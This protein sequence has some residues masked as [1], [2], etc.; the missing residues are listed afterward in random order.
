MR[1]KELRNFNRLKDITTTL[2][3]HG[4]HHFVDELGLPV[5]AKVRS[6]FHQ[7]KKDWPDIAESLPS[8]LKSVFQDLGPTFIKLGQIL[9]T[10]HDLLGRDFITELEKLQ[11]EVSPM[12]FEEVHRV[13]EEE[14]GDSVEEL[15]RE[16]QAEPLGSA[17]I[18][19][20][21]RAV[22][23]EGR[24]LVVKVQRPGIKDLIH[25]DIEVLRFVAK[26]M[27]DN[28]IL[29]EIYDPE[30]IVE[31]F[32]RSIKK[33]LDYFRELRN[34]YAF[35]KNFAEVEHIYLPEVF[36]ELSTDKVLCMEYVDG[37]KVSQ[38][39]RGKHDF[40]LIA[41]RGA[42]AV[43]KQVFEDG[44]FH[45]DPHPGNIMIKGSAQVCFIDFGMVGRLSQKM[46]D[47][48][49]SLL[50]AMSNRDY[51][52]LAR[53]VIRICNPRR[54]VDTDELATALLETMDPFYGATLGQI[55]VG[56]LI[57]ECLDVIARHKIKFPSAYSL[58]FKSLISIES[59]G[60]KLDP[61]F[62]LMAAARPFVRALVLKRF[63][64]ERLQ[65]DGLLAIRD[66]TGM[67][68]RL[69]Y[70]LEGL[71]A[72]MLRGDF[73]IEFMHK[74]LDSLIR[75]IDEGSNR[76]AFSLVISACIMA[77]SFVMTNESIVRLWGMNMGVVM[78]VVA[79]LLGLWLALSILRS[80]RM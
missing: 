68:N 10:R 76:I 40:E 12:P 64:L 74:G 11:D 33:E 44:C 21:H 77:S 71:L 43:L 75:Q 3:S 50:F 15:F 7:E 31:E 34:I 60:R 67:L 47:N 59:L 57:Q 23:K 13:I 9:S 14:L 32:A 80:G 29:D 62:D 16:F 54:E 37:I 56:Q 63:G 58:I 1:L 28:E 8:R 25:S 26:L 65:R 27:K 38:I 39:E 41:E 52:V 70:R 18:G 61:N 79:G 55:D 42:N 5:M 35:R 45:A 19:Q 51:D 22:S 53:E 6:M 48:L 24:E 78:W 36:P 49:S 30:A 66:V 20:V 4:L 17:S 2:L 46:R 69:P 72:K 73:S